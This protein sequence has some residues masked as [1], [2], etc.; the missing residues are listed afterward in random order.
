ML[1]DP[2][3]APPEG[4]AGVD[5]VDGAPG[6]EVDGAVGV[7]AAGWPGPAPPQATDSVNTTAIHGSVRMGSQTALAP[8]PDTPPDRR[9]HQGGVTADEGSSPASSPVATSGMMPSRT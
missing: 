8:R 7:G 2:D 9:L 6:A 5:G 3:D 1:Q 4:G